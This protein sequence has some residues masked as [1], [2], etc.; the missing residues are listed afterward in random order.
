MLNTYTEELQGDEARAALKRGIDRV[1]KPVAATMGAKGRNAVYREYGRSKPTNDGVSI[2]LRI[3]PKNPFEKLGAELIKEA[4]EQTVSEAGDGT[5]GTI[6]FSDAL[7]EA[8]LEEVA[9]GKS[10]MEL[11]AELDEAKV[12]VVEAIQKQSK[13]VS[14]REDI[15]NVARVSVEDEEMAQMVADAVGKAGEHGAITVEQ[16]SGY[17]LEREDVQG[18]FWENGFV[19]PYMITNVERNE[20]VLEDVPVIVTDRYMNLNHDLVFTINE[21]MKQ[22]HGSALVIVDRMEGELL[23]T[24]IGNKIKGNFTTVVVRKPETKEELEDIATL[25]NGTAVTK[26]LGIKQITP[27]HIGK[28]KRVVVTEKK[29]IIIADSSPALVERVKNLEEQIKDKDLGNRELFVKRL[30]K[31]SDGIVVIRVGAKTEAEIKYRKDKLDDAVNAAKAATE[32]GVSAGGGV[33]LYKIAAELTQTTVGAQV[34]VR[35]LRKPFEQIL[36]NAGIIPDGNF[37]NVKTGK[38]VKDM[39]KEGIIDPTK[40]LRCIVENGTSFAG[41]FLT[42]ETAIADFTEETTQ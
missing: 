29:T 17:K 25:V 14:S 36:A 23:T 7:V 30:A 34:M 28:A 27:M 39:V 15:L 24:V 41:T 37:Y 38:K 5:T 6:V 16:G 18:Y 12:L 40:V 31:L 33:T 35:A 19:S 3:N 21:L 20:A 11:R 10:P 22:G 8:G 42:L 32:E 2:A 1:V 26:D 4:A 13:S 9:K